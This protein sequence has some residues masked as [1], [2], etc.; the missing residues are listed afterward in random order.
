MRQG[1]TDEPNKGYLK[2]GLS[3]NFSDILE[4]GNLYFAGKFLRVIQAT[5]LLPNENPDQLFS[6]YPGFC[7][8][9]KLVLSTL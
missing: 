5:L 2:S 3:L 8:I 1:F 6:G 7:F 9:L 4:Y